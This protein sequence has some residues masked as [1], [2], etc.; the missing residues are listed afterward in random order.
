MTD[1]SER[2]KVGPG[3]KAKTAS[4]AQLLLA[5]PEAGLPYIRDALANP[6]IGEEHVVMIAR[7]RAADGALLQRL[8]ADPRW[9]RSYDVKAAVVRNAKTPRH[10]AMN[11]VRFLFWRDLAHVVEDFYLAP[12]LRR[13]AEKYL[14]ERIPDL[15]VGEKIALARIAGRGLVRRMLEETSPQ[16]LDALLWNPRLTEQD[17]LV[18]V[19]SPSTPVDTL[20]ILARHPRWFSRYG[21]RVALI[22]NP[23]TPLPV[24]LGIVTSLTERDLHALADTPET[25]QILKLACLRVLDDAD[26]RRR[27]AEEP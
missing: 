15:A 12:P 20:A 27:Q 10:V 26:W 14:S 16:V 13:L 19:N 24:S 6:D 2:R 7:S 17:L 18:T 5:I 11:L 22:R 4:A 23:R 21:I 1:R 25:P 8:S 9:I 3:V